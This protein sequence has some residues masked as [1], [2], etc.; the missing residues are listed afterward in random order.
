[1]QMRSIDRSSGWKG[2]LQ[3]QIKH[4]RGNDL[5]NLKLHYILRIV[6]LYPTVSLSS[7]DIRGHCQS[8]VT[9]GFNT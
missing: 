3:F 8:L 6:T 1:M 7:K 4:C 9:K 5:K 2:R